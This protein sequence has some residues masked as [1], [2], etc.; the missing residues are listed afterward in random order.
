[1]AVVNGYCTT[2]DVRDQFG[3]PDTKLTTALLEKAINAASRAI[4]Q[5]CRRRFWLD[6][7]VSTR[8][9]TVACSDHAYIDDIGSRT[10]LVV[11]IGTDGIS[12]PTTLTA[13][14]DF[15]LEPRN[16]DKYATAT[17][18]AYAF[19]KI[20]TVGTRWLYVGGDL[21]TLQVT[22]RFGWS[23][24]PDDVKQACILKAGSLFKRKDAPF[25]VA[26]FGEF[27]VVR[28]SKTDPDVVDL[29]SAYV[30]PVA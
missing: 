4:D 7:A 30:V 20:R 11:A 5:H 1:M 10:G 24:V 25:G 23:A 27:G 12:Y 28:V 17:F 15:I 29:L 16:A 21:P 6:T 2:Q 9:F 13:G 26:G 19:W 3:D 8:T 18:D 22:A 14:T